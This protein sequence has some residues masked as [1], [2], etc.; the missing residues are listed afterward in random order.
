VKIIYPQVINTLPE[1]RHYLPDP[2]GSDESLRY[3]DRDYF[4][5]VMYAL[6]PDTVE[7]LLKQAS[8]AKKVPDKN[9]QEEQWTMAITQEWMDQLL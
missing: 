6:Y 7:E 4:Y 2:Q 8:A 3:P 1:L 5:R 9:L